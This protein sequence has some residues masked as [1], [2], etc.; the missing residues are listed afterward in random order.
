MST[1][2]I[3]SAGRSR[4]LAG[5]GGLATGLVGL[6]FGG[7]LVGGGCVGN[8]SRAARIL[9]FDRRTLYRKLGAEGPD[10]DEDQVAP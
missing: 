7:G 8:K 3:G 2:L 9:G 5:S 1:V 10:D 4:S 6:G